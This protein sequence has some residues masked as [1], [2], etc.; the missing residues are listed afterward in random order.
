MSEIKYPAINGVITAERRAE[1]QRK[2]SG[3]VR[4]RIRSDGTFPGTS[5]VAVH[6]DGTEHEVV[7]CDR[8]DISVTPSGARAAIH[9]TGVEAD[10]E[11]APGAAPGPAGP[12]LNVAVHVHGD[13]SADA[14]RDVV[15][16]ALEQAALVERAA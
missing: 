12:I 3:A 8:V 1:E 15:L 11:A 9:V 6:E 2:V 4:L 7:L 5:V 13:A 14:A 10:V 16:K